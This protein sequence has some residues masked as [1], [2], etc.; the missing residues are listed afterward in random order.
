VLI[1]GAA[2]KEENAVKI[3]ADEIIPLARAE[4]LWTTSVHLTIDIQRVHADQLR[5]LKKVFATYR[6]SSKGF[7]HL[8]QPQ[9]AEAVIA[10]P[11]SM[12]LNVGGD[13]VR[14]VESV[15]GYRAVETTCS[16]QPQN[17][18]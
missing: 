17:V 6:G 1:R 12:R 3:I 11:D 7:L 2:Q 14:A 4:A 9:R 15:L 5:D 18:L 8:L 10:L 13:F 16:S